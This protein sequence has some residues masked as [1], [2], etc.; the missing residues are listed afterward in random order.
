M[1]VT[2]LEQE[3]E[4]QGWQGYLQGPS[5]GPPVATVS[6][7]PGAGTERPGGDPHSLV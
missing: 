3:E 6:T 7:W 4:T 1:F 5:S 2:G